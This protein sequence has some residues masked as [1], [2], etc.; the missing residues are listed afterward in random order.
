MLQNT[1]IKYNLGIVHGFVGLRAD[2][3]CSG[4]N[5]QFSLV[6]TVSGSVIWASPFC[7]VL[8]QWNNVEKRGWNK[9]C[10][11]KSSVTVKGMLNKRKQNCASVKMLHN[12]RGTQFLLQGRHLVKYYLNCIYIVINSEWFGAIVIIYESVNPTLSRCQNHKWD[13]E[14]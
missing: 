1:T 13:V 2:L 6:V 3:N 5:Y 10:D 11:I 4:I 12:I 7:F 9:V 8:F 14:K